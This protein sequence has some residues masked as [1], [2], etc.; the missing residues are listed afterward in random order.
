MLLAML[1]CVVSA[2]AQNFEVD[3]ISYNVTKAPDE[4]SPGEVEV[5]GGEI[6][7]E[8]EIPETVI[9]N[10]VTYTVTVIGNG[11]F[12]GRSNSSNFTKKYI[13]PG[14][15]KSIGSNAF[16]DNY[17]LEEVEFHEGLQTIG[18]DAF[19]YNFA[20]KEIR[21]P[22][23][24][25]SIED[26]AFRTN[27]QNK[28]TISCLAATPPANL[29]SETFEGRTDATLHVK[30]SYV[31]AYKEV[32]YWKDFSEIVGNIKCYSPVIANDND[33]LT[34]SCE[35]DGATIYYTTDGSVPDGNAARYTS[36]I[37][38]TT[39]QIIRA[40]AIAEGYE[41]SAVRN[42]YDKENLENTTDEQGVK[43]TLKQDDD[44]NF[45][46][47]VTGHSDELNT[48][49]VIP[50]DLGGCPVR[51]IEAYAFSWCTGLS[52][53]SIPNSVTSIGENAFQ[54]CILRPLNYHE[55]RK[56]T[57]FKSLYYNHF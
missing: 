27:Q 11:A 48:D 35:T 56:L 46:Y 24:V 10:N 42:Y 6:K 49:I 13:I 2:Y 39:N 41:N 5:T 43:Y 1:S 14:T 20:L 15:V 32:E 31:E 28:A 47:S 26:R 37:S 52:S 12:S 7:E 51:T 29:G 3:G 50:A 4:E 25:T 53:I 34:M 19:G 33:I 44:N 17:Y 21:I 8:I 54:G 57:E 45:Y 30:A 9:Y 22:S 36:P 55:Q 16:Y 38:Y 40:I 18:Y 23:T